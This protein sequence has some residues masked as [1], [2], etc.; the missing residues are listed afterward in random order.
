LVCTDFGRPESL[1][2]LMTHFSSLVFSSRFLKPYDGRRLAA[3]YELRSGS[4]WLILFL[5]QFS[6][7][8]LV[9]DPSLSRWDLLPPALFFS[10]RLF[11]VKDPWQFSFFMFGASCCC[12][13]VSHLPPGWRALLVVGSTDYGSNGSPAFFPAPFSSQFFK[14]FLPLSSREMFGSR[15]SFFFRNYVF[16][17]F[18]PAGKSFFCRLPGLFFFFLFPGRR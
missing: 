5:T 17:C 4:G 8:T 18:P 2:L 10:S 7:R 12:A 9:F 1:F 6:T 16:G 3:A 13:S 15:R 14:F 11:F